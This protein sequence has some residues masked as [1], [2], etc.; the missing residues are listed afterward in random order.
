MSNG[1]DIEYSEPVNLTDY[2][3]TSA[4]TLEATGLQHAADLV[5][6]GVVE[7][8][9]TDDL[10]IVSQAS[11]DHLISENRR[12]ERLLREIENSDVPF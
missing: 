4:S 7:Q 5:G 3:A 2:L 12:L 1:P 6:E 10:T 11:L 8:L 9:L